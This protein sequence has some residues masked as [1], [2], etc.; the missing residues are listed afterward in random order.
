[1]TPERILTGKQSG[2]DENA[3]EDE[4]GHDGVALQPVAED[5]E[6]EQMGGKKWWVKKSCQHFTQKYHP[7]SIDRQN[8]SL[9][10]WTLLAHLIR[11]EEIDSNLKKT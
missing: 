2:R 7:L 10:F 9:I 6:Q 11:E 3:D 5:P 1:M 4:V 8:S